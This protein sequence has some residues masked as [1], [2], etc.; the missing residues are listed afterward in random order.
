MSRS[1]VL[2]TLYHSFFYSAFAA[3]YFLHDCMCMMYVARLIEMHAGNI[4][5]SGRTADGVKTLS[6]LESARSQGLYLLYL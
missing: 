2:I 5:P 6:R 4:M 1:N 3:L